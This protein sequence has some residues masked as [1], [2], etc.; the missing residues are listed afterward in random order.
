[1]TPATAVTLCVR[2]NRPKDL[3][4]G[5]LCKRCRAPALPKCKECGEVCWRIGGVCYGC[6]PATGDSPSV[7]LPTREATPT[8]A[9][10][11]TPEK[12][13]ELERRYA[14]AER[15]WSREDVS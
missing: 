4:K 11:G 9:R 12:C 8:K 13:R 15:L 6:S 1:M 10:P 14:N 3:V 5:R 7:I 2:C